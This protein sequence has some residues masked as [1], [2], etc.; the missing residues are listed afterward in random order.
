MSR[1]D[2]DL[3]SCLNRDVSSEDEAASLLNM[4]DAADN[5][6]KGVVSSYMRITQTSHAVT[7]VLLLDFYS[8]VCFKVFI[9]F[10]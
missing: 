9:Y 8:F 1:P 2:C 5:K 6:H 7:K 10:S 3:Y 4:A